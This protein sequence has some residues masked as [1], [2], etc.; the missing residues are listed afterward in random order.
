MTV[1]TV[2]AAVLV[3]LLLRPI[4]TTIQNY[5]EA[6][7]VGLPIFLT[8]IPSANP[9]MFVLGPALF[10]IMKA[11]PGP[12]CNW[13]RYGD[14]FW[15]F[16]DR[17]NPIAKFGPAFI[18]VSPGKTQLHVS[19]PAGGD[20]LLSRPKH[21][22]KPPE[23]YGAIEI[24]GP[25]VDTVNGKTWNRHRKLTTPPFNERNSG[26]VWRESIA[27]AKGMM[28]S[29]VQ[30]A[31][32]GIVQTSSDTMKL[33]LHVLTGAG[34][35]Q[36][37]D[38]QVGL[39]KIP[40]GHAMSY[41]D[42]LAAILADILTAILIVKLPVSLAFI[43]KFKAMQLACKEF[44]Q[45]MVEMVHA[46]RSANRA[47][48]KDN[49][50]SVLVK[51]ADSSKSGGAARESL[52]DDEIYGN[53]FIWNLA[54]HDTTANTL[55]Y[56]ITLLSVNP[57]MQDWI[58][59]EILAVFGPSSSPDEWDYDSAF[60][61][62]KRIMALMYETLRLYGPVSSMT[63]TTAD[64]PQAL[65]IAGK[66]YEIPARWFVHINYVALHSDPATWGANALSW[67]PTRF[68]SASNDLIT[69]ETGT[70]MP[71]A[72]GPRVCPGK[73]FAQVEFV[74]VIAYLFGNYRVRPVLEKG[75]TLEQ[76]KARV[77]E[78]VEDSSLEASPTLKM[79][80]PEKVA[81]VWSSR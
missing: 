3:A 81:L 45:Y 65:R 21:F 42:A 40:E 4:W 53:L 34:F 35:G 67:D 7:K 49:L 78:V 54:G 5:K 32:Q 10:P 2:V 47:D 19:D 16:Q 56:A 46:E 12:I 31:D 20:E 57:E 29:W 73:K 1:V 23:I 24:F 6:R 8:P 66:S 36:T 14:M 58:G 43:P 30:A 52:S 13:A 25:N 9:L 11:L 37:Y 70:F 41:R 39:T 38:Y 63:K 55:A 22:L 26:L 28:A 60:P 68:T 51:A 33:A 69:P 15:H 18:V 72:S 44:K 48:S 71:W 76:A 17:A 79:R 77:Q 62:L 80:H 27:Q 50:M 64:T 74:A 75:E 61:Q 59:Q